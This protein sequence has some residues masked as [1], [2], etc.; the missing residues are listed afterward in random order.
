MAIVP[1]RKKKKVESTK[2]RPMK[3]ENVKRLK[4]VAPKGY[5]AEENRARGKKVNSTRKKRGY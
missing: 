4:K 3:P 5:V 2:V 1:V